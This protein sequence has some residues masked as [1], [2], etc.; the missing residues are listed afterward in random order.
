VMAR[1]MSKYEDGPACRT[2]TDTA[3]GAVHRRSMTGEGAC[4]AHSFAS[5]AGSYS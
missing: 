4:R 2:A 5:S 3:S 1:G